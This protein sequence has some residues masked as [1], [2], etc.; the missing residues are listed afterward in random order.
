MKRHYEIMQTMRTKIP[1]PR[2]IWDS[3]DSIILVHDAVSY[4]MNDLTGILSLLSL[5]IRHADLIGVR[6]QLFSSKD[7]S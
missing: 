7:G 3:V 6:R 2:E 1:H 5:L 4:R